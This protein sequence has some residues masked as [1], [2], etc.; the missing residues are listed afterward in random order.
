MICP[1]CS[2]EQDDANLECCRCGLIFKKYR[3]QQFAL[4]EPA[5]GA[6]DTECDAAGEADGGPSKILF[7]VEPQVNP[8]YFLGRV[9]VFALIAVWGLKLI[10][11]P[12]QSNYV[13]SSFMHLINLP[14]HEAGHVFFRPLGSLLTSLGGTLGQL[15]MPLTCL[16]TL[17]LKSKNT[18]G[19]AVCLWWFG[20][21]LLDIAPYINDAR[22][23][24]LMLLGGNI[25]QNTPYG[26]HDWEFILTETGLLRYDHLIAGI[27]FKLGAGIMV[28]AV[29][30]AGYL[31]YKQY[32][33]LDLN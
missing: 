4:Q 26:F 22:E 3:E 2:C 14:F 6:E 25:G 30:W 17:L 31:L 21:N 8:I 28:M 1:K 23:L 33:R 15:L 29:V 11:H 32:R 5:A 9:L 7:F 10:T 27:V 12:M 19:A 24:K 18:F 13:G 20:E 16:L